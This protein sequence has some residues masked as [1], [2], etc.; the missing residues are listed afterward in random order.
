MD[1]LRSVPF[2]SGLDDAQL[3]A[4]AG[5]MA[6][7]TYRTREVI[8]HGD[9][10]GDSLYVITEGAVKIYLSS[11]DGKEAVLAVLGRGDAFGELSLLDGL[12]RSDSA[13]ALEPVS[14]LLLRSESFWEFVRQYPEALRLLARNLAHLV[15]RETS[16]L[17]DALFLDLPAR[18]AR[19]L[20]DLAAHSGERVDGGTL[21]RLPLT[22]SELADMVG[23]TR[24]TVNRLLGDLKASGTIARE[25]RYLVVR[26]VKALRAMAGEAGWA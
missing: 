23:A 4:L 1:A 16:L 25:G 22:Q 13:A 8:F 11:P 5:R 7:R 10:P 3:A 26:D 24:V 14:A 17:G 12:P 18:L 19:R 6:Q 20:L 15:R 9:D 2:F 21:V